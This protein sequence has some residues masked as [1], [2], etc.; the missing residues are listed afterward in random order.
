MR[1][2]KTATDEVRSWIQTRRGH[3]RT[4]TTEPEPRSHRYR[5]QNRQPLPQRHT[6]KVVPH[7]RVRQVSLDL[8]D[9][10][11]LVEFGDFGQRVGGDEPD[12]RSTRISGVDQREI[13]FHVPGGEHADALAVERHSFL[14]RS[15]GVITHPPQI[16]GEGPVHHE[17][18]LGG[19][20]FALGLALGGGHLQILCG[21]GIIAGLRRLEKPEQSS[22]RRVRPS[23]S[24]LT[25]LAGVPPVLVRD[26]GN[27]WAAA[28]SRAAKQSASQS[29]RLEKDSMS[30]FLEPHRSGFSWPINVGA[31]AEKDFCR[32]H[33][34]F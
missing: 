21:G 26:S 6:E 12:F 27:S 13:G 19:K 18:Q 32:F 8:A 33:D 14:R 9:L 29:F 17:F 20:V 1:F 34:S 2:R 4:R 25:P 28:G 7:Q 15:V 3:R 5:H 23:G 31:G 30:A 24:E 10:V 11:L 22:A 16:S